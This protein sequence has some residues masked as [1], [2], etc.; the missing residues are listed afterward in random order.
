M[1]ARRKE[2]DNESSNSRCRRRRRRHKVIY[3]IHSNAHLLQSTRPPIAHPPLFSTLGYG[4]QNIIL[5]DV[6]EP[7]WK[8]PSG[9]RTRKAT[10]AARCSI[11]S[12]WTHSAAERWKVMLCP[13]TFHAART[14]HIRLLC[15]FVCVR[16]HAYFYLTV[17]CF[18][19][20]YANACACRHYRVV[21]VRLAW[22]C[23]PV[24]SYIGVAFSLD[25]SGIELHF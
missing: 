8:F 17:V 25:I 24:F 23:V 2:T 20:Q 7:E 16:R 11:I 15:V 4:R 9:S 5:V 13:L 22:R 12:H 14:V 6:V 10:R 19:L 3:L 1:R 18:F 21:M